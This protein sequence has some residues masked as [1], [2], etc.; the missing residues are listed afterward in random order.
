MKLK[1]ELNDIGIDYCGNICNS[2]FFTDVYPKIHHTHNNDIWIDSSDVYLVFE[3][4]IDRG[5]Y[6]ALSICRRYR[7]I[8][9]VHTE[10]YELVFAKIPA[11]PFLS[12]DSLFWEACIQMIIRKTLMHAGFSNGSPRVRDIFELD[13]GTIGYT[14]D[15][16]FGSKSFDNLLANSSKKDFSRLI[17]EGICQVASMISILQRKLGFNHRDLR[18]ANLL[19][20]D[21]GEQDAQNMKFSNLIV[22]DEN[23]INRYQYLK[24]HSALEFT[25]IDFGF[26]CFGDCHDCGRFCL[27]GRVYNPLDI[28]PK[29]GR[30]MFM[31]LAFLLAE[32]GDKMDSNL[33]RY[34]KK[35]LHAS[36]GVELPLSVAKPGRGIYQFLRRYGLKAD[37]WIYFIAGNKN[38]ISIRSTNALNIVRNLQEM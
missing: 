35:W 3:K 25:L 26:T 33:R 8:K 9:R 21:V 2:N 32:F 5:A 12:R 23:D 30:D 11:R 4:F 28:C 38:I 36:C 22:F 27:N 13:D 37:K 31:F 18:A 15:I 19:C 17:I 10:E 16:I 29:P 20:R 6:G 24:V 1:I 14:M 7:G 34:F